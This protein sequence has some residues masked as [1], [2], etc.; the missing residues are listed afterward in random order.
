MEGGLG[1][2]GEGVISALYTRCRCEP[3]PTLKIKSTKNN[4]THHMRVC[5]L[6]ILILN[7]LLLTDRPFGRQLSLSDS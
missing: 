5:Q 2:A 7:F 3:K 1:T 6:W 4:P